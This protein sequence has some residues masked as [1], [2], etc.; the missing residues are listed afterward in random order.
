[1]PHPSSLFPEIKK[2][3]RDEERPGKKLNPDLSEIEVK[4]SVT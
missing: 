2:E 3:R 4:R 1:M